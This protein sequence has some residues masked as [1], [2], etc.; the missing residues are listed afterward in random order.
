MKIY[1]SVLYPYPLTSY[2]LLLVRVT[3]SGI[4]CSTY[5]NHLLLEFSIILVIFSINEYHH[6]LELNDHQWENNKNNIKFDNKWLES[7]LYRWRC[8][9]LPASRA[10]PSRVEIELRWNRAELELSR[11]GT[12]SSWN[13]AKLELH[14]NSIFIIFM[15]I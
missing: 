8:V 3:E 5:L 4:H 14:M 13:R 1:S 15:L 7:Q 9:G 2:G 12:E 11:V 10:K 6:K